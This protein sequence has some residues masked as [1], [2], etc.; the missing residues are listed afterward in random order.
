MKIVHVVNYFQHQLGYQEYFLAREHAK[1]GH[2]VTVLTSDRYDL[3]LD[4]EDTVENI[5]GKRIFGEKIEMIDG[6]RVIR[7]KGLFEQPGRRIWLKGLAG[8]IKRINPDLV[9]SH[10]EYTYSSLELSIL[11]RFHRFPLIVDSHTI[12]KR[13]RTS[14]RKQLIKFPVSFLTLWIYRI[15]VFRNRKTVWVPCAS[16][17]ADYLTDK[18]GIPRDRMRIIPLGAD[19]DRFKPD[20]TMRNVLRKKLGIED[21]EIV[22]IYTGR[23]VFEKDPVLI[24]ESLEPW[25][26][27][28]RFKVMFVGNVGESY[29]ERFNEFH[30]K[31]QSRILLIDAVPNSE[32]DKYYRVADIAVWPKS[33]S[34]SNIDAMSSGLPIIVNDYLTERLKNNNGIGIKEGDVAQLREA[35][36][37]LIRDKN[38]R[39]EMG[40]RGRELV[41][42]EMSWSVIAQKFLDLV[43]SDINEPTG[44]CFQ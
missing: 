15:L 37:T 43:A 18:Y 26:N 19:T 10:G 27:D 3:F 24:L 33:V 34:I 12:E 28:Y 7:L 1:A 6:F 39:Q 44:R 11:Q 22:I 14:F 13:S 32:L 9:I 25:V 8:W 29:G 42:K 20:T 21:D 23:I 36:L 5:L 41:E 35:I 40:K 16:V 2:E 38:L 4:Y 31:L 30:S 17:I